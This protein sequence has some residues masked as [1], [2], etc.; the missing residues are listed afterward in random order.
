MNS[1]VSD[2]WYEH[3]GHMQV[4]ELTLNAWRALQAV[5]AGTSDGYTV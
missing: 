5:T 4:S 1:A 2:F 3:L